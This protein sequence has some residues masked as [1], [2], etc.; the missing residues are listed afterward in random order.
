MPVAAHKAHD[1]SEEQDIGVRNDK[2]N[3]RGLARSGPEFPSV[4][5]RAEISDEEC[6]VNP[7]H[8]KLCGRP[9]LRTASDDNV[10]R[11]NSLFPESLIGHRNGK[12]FLFREQHGIDGEIPLRHTEQQCRFQNNSRREKGN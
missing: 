3:R 6:T 11:Q 1:M 7:N 10:P 5:M 9:L 12:E 4:S 8:N 2:A